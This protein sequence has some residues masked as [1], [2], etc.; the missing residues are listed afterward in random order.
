MAKYI[1]DEERQKKPKLPDDYLFYADRLKN[2]IAVNKKLDEIMRSDVDPYTDFRLPQRDEAEDFQFQTIKKRVEED[3]AKEPDST[4]P[5]PLPLILGPGAEVEYS[6][7]LERGHCMYCRRPLKWQL[8]PPGMNATD[9]RHCFAKCCGRLFA[10]VPKTVTILEDAYP[11]CLPGVLPPLDEEGPVVT[12]I[13]DHEY[14]V[15]YTEYNRRVQALMQ[16][17][18]K[19][20]TT[21]KLD[22]FFTKKA[23]Q[24]Y[25]ES[26]REFFKY[27]QEFD[28]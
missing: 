11:D 27:K 8:G 1:S 6:D 9:D 20:D 3:Q 21:Q 17:D 18:H 16:S 14:R 12:F 2:D 15:D 22:D 26:V 28:R 7:A 4:P 13:N 5:D 25:D 23:Q 19:S 24:V 10:M